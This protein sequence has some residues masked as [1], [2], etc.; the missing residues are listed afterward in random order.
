MKQAIEGLAFYCG[1]F[2][3]TDVIA[4][5]RF[6]PYQ[7]PD[8]LARYSLIDYDSEP[9]FVDPETGKSPYKVIVAG[10]EFGVGSSRETAPLGLHYAG[11]EVIIAKSF[12]TIFYRNCINMGI[13]LPI[14]SDHPFDQSIIGKPVVVDL[15]AGFFSIE[16]QRYKIPDFGPVLEIIKAG[17]LTHYTRQRMENR[18]Q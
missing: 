7:G 12:A 17:G 9:P 1:D 15:E 14:I 3:N 6:E 13:I 18:Q 16:G 11:C 10:R 4:P 2:V 8:E 5:G